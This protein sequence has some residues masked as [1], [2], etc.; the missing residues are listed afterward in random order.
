MI[1]HTK[2]FKDAGQDFTTASAFDGTVL[3]YER[4][5]TAQG[6]ASKVLIEGQ[7]VHCPSTSLMHPQATISA[8]KRGERAMWGTVP[9]TVLSVYWCYGTARVCVMRD[10]RAVDTDREDIPLSALTR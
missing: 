3:A 8:F 2:E 7:W 9:C 4:S 5:A 6:A 10:C 1:D